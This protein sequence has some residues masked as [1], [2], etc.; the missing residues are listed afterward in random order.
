MARVITARRADT[1]GDC[2]GAIAAGEQINYGGYGAVTH[3]ACEPIESTVRS[4][5]SHRASSG[6][7]YSYT[8][9]THEDFP[10]CGCER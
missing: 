1:C 2:T 7:R 5:R 3:A 9:C 8:R 4:G 6:R 10:C